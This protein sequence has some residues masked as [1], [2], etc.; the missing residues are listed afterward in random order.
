MEHLLMNENS[1]L[2]TKRP[3]V[4]NFHLWDDRKTERHNQ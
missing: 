1:R 3:S 4:C 2:P